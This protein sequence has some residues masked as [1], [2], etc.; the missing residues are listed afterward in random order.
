MAMRKEDECDSSQVRRSL[1]DDRVNTSI[2]DTRGGQIHHR[3]PHDDGAGGRRQCISRCVP[4]LA[5]E[6]DKSSWAMPA[7]DEY[8]RSVVKWSIV[9]VQSG[10]SS[11]CKTRTHHGTE[12]PVNGRSKYASPFIA[13]S[14]ARS[15]PQRRSDGCTRRWN[16]TPTRLTSSQEIATHDALSARET[17]DRRF[18]IWFNLALFTFQ[19]N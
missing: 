1:A 14:S 12:W 15:W 7:E 5:D 9:H 3:S 13:G 16:W 19:Q 11:A 10:R 17:D 4:S 18:W 2:P 8:N 6:R